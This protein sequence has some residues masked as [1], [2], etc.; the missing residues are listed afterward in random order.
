M[1]GPLFP[2]KSKKPFHSA[3]DTLNPFRPITVHLRHIKEISL[4]AFFCSHKTVTSK[5][6]FFHSHIFITPKAAVLCR[7]IGVLLQM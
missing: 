5:Y 7:N 4:T 3:A 1:S 6:S 2:Q